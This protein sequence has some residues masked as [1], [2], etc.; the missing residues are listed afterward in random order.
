MLKKKTNIPLNKYFKNILLTND[1]GYDAIGIKLLY[2]LLQKYADNAILL[3]PLEPMSCKSSSIT[4][5]KGLVINKV[6]DNVFALNGTPTDCVAIGLSSLNIKFDLVVSGVN[7]GENLTYD[8]I[9]SG[10]IGATLE[11]N[12]EGYKSISFSCPSNFNLVEKNFDQVMNIVIKNNL[13]SKKYTLSVN[14]PLGEEV[15]D[16][17]V[18]R[19]SSRKDHP[20]Y[21]K[22]DG[23][24][25]ARRE[26]ESLIS[27]SEDDWYCFNNG[28]VS[29]VPL[30]NLLFH[31]HI[32]RQAKNKNLKKSNK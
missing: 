30:T 26:I 23:A 8:T 4:M 24:Y 7:D 20:Y 1:D 13:L 9:Y 28:I 27:S 2:K 22:I 12:K 29:I 3:A 21:E 14:F 16:I 6:S 18:S 10:T 25:Y 31:E 11:A 32:Y 19:L 5:G 17:M 15:K